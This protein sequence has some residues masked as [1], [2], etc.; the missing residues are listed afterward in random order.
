MQS[1]A[2]VND[3]SVSCDG[4]QGRRPKQFNDFGR[5]RFSPVYL[6]EFFTRSEIFA[7]GKEELRGMKPAAFV[8]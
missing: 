3:D 1:V 7:Q 6:T 5:R 8:A 2:I 4:T